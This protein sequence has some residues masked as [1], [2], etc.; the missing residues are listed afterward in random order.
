VNL[1]DG[2]NQS[3]DIPAEDV[4]LVPG[5]DFSQVT[6]RLPDNLAAGTYHVK[7]VFG[8]QFSN[9]TSIRVGN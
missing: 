5:F 6:F 1:V 2:G 8:N 9:T 4:R 7:V 3:R